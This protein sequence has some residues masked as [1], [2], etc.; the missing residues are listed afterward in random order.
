M[1][2][3]R[4]YIRIMTGF[5]MNVKLLML[6]TF[7]ISLYTGIYGIIFN[8]YVLNMGY[9]AD[10]LGLLL[11]V[12]L[13]ASSA[14]SI[15]AGILCDRF[16]KKKLLMISGIMTL[17]VTIPLYIT[18]SPYLMLALSALGGVFWSI[19]AVAV[20]P[21]LAENC[22]SD[23]NVHI[24]STNASLG[25]IASI[26]GCAMGGIIPTVWAA[27][28]GLGGSYRMTLLTAVVLLAAGLA[29]AAMLK[30]NKTDRQKA[31]IS[32]LSTGTDRQ[33]SVLA[34]GAGFI[35]SLKGIRISSDVIKFT[36]TSI[37]FGI[38]SGMIVPYFNVYFIR[39]M[40]VGVIEVG[41]ASAIA[42]AVMITGLMATPYLT[43]KI[44]KVRCAV[45]TKILSAPFL[46]FM[47]L[48]TNFIMAA[49]AYVAYMFLINMAGPATTSF[50]MELI[51][52]K[53]QGLAV[54]VMSTGSYVAISASTYVSGLLIAQGNYIIPF[55]CTCVAYLA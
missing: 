10:F 2:I 24:F 42:G 18:G 8:L 12:N 6:R 28:F 3:I 46:I 53:E 35:A 1:D 19:S 23:D 36:I 4:D 50:Q 43:S 41:L 51:K 45:L 49:G 14:T 13:L 48:T 20:T 30:T 39:V 29:L 32:A 17:A 26:L 54:G 11:A 52:P 47:A 22:H 25:W 55:V 34:R 27:A 9:H 37:T 15:P 38:A 40:K 44:G 16:N 7:L 21:L 31:T 5:H 33:K